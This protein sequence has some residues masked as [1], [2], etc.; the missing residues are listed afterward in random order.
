MYVRPL[1]IH[2]NL[3]DYMECVKELNNPDI[4]INSIEQMKRALLSRP[5][6]IITY[7]VVMEDKIVAAAT[8]IFEKKIRYQKLCCHIEDVGVNKDFRKQGLGKIIVDHCVFVAKLK[9]CYK[10]KLFCSDHLEKFYSRL[11][12]NKTNAGM[13]QVLGD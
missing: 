13:E 2:D 6:N 1:N 4:E 12:F 8:C 3:L 10:V 9:K 5:G 11:G 7:V